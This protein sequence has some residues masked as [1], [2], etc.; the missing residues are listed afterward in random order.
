MNNY[1]KC[2]LNYA[3]G[4]FRVLHELEKYFPKNIHT[5]YDLFGGAGNVTANIKAN[6]Y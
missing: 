4:K 2:P 5:L 1:C 6:K 3:G